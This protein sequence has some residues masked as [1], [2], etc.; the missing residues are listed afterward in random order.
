MIRFFLYSEINPG[1]NRLSQTIV[2]GKVPT[3]LSKCGLLFESRREMELVILFA[4]YH[5]ELGQIQNLTDPALKNI[6]EL[7]CVAVDSELERPRVKI[8][9]NE[10]P[11]CHA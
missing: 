9:L 11:V 5:R 7:P 1:I 8:V 4:M 6:K 2:G 10:Y 3:P